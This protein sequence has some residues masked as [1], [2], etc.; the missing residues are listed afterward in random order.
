MLNN[1]CNKSVQNKFGARLFKSRS[2]G[3]RER[4][5]KRNSMLGK[6]AG[7]ASMLTKLFIDQQGKQKLSRSKNLLFKYGSR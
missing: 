1:N 4:G 2:M 3:S 7:S 5:A 6:R